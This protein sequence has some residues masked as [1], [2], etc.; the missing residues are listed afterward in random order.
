MNLDRRI[1]F[2]IILV[3]IIGAAAGVYYMQSGGGERLDIR[4]DT[5]L[6]GWRTKEQKVYIHIT[7]IGGTT[8][9]VFAIRI[10]PEGNYTFYRD[11]T[12]PP[13]VDCVIEFSIW[14]GPVNVTTLSGS[15]PA[16]GGVF[17]SPTWSG[18]LTSGVY[19]TVM[20]YTRTGNVYTL[21]HVEVR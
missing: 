2:G 9:E 3:I 14:G 8:I 17:A 16:E 18:N 7:N 10:L 4:P 6:Y 1:I 20:I 11:I 5:R 12:I 21:D 13:G 15:P 19:R